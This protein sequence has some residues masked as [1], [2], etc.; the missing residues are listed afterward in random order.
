MRDDGSNVSGEQHKI[1]LRVSENKL[2]VRN[3]S[4]RVKRGDSDH[5]AGSRAR[6][7]ISGFL[8]D[9]RFNKNDLYNDTRRAALFIPLPLLKARK[10]SSA[11]RHKATTKADRRKD[12][13]VG[14]NGSADTTWDHRTA[15]RRRKGLL[16]VYP[17]KEVCVISRD[18]HVHNW[19]CTPQI[20]LYV[21]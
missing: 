16:W 14:N 13:R 10:L 2:A 9:D 21:S 11:S 19:R 20:G 15:A 8:T 5:R 6:W 4:V 18:R 17:R 3:L 7:M 12:R 1:D